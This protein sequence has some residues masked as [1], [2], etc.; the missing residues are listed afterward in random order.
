MCVCL[1]SSYCLLLL[2]A[3]HNGIT[4]IVGV[5]CLGHLFQ[6][7]KSKQTNVKTSAEAPFAAANRTSEDY[8]GSTDDKM[9]KRS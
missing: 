7:V 3:A 2:F 9:R 5:F 4:F 6:V 1:S 8:N